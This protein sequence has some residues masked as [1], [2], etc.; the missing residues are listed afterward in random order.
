MQTVPL[1]P[2][3]LI[4]FG[5]LRT[6]WVPSR[7]REMQ[8]S[9]YLQAH[10]HL[11]RIRGLNV[12][13]SV[14]SSDDR[15]ADTIRSFVKRTKADLVAVTSRRRSIL[16]RVFRRNTTEQLIHGVQVPILVVPSDRSSLEDVRELSS[17]KQS[18]DRRM[19]K[20]YMSNRS[21]HSMSETFRKHLVHS[22]MLLST[23]NAQNHGK[24]R[25]A[26]ANPDQRLLEAQLDRWTNE[27]GA[28]SSREI[29][30]PSLSR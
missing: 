4:R 10:A 18:H 29:S 17:S 13:T 15:V 30:S 11:M 9:E 27:G 19:M 1:E 23:T 28:L 6:D 16:S 5:A 22:R 3:H 25:L 2:E 26:T 8:S 12:R 21:S 24:R 20:T 7:K 14:I